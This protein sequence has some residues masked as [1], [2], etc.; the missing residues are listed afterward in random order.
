MAEIDSVIVFKKRVADLSLGD[1]VYEAMVA[2]GWDT[3]A[4]FAFSAAYLPGA[5]GAQEV[6]DRILKPLLG[7]AD[8]PK[9]SRLRRLFFESYTLTIGD[10]RSAVERKSEDEPR[11]MNNTER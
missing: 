4:A 11:R 3:R 10:M 7:S 5:Q 8:H 9:A 2:K 6:E 1:E